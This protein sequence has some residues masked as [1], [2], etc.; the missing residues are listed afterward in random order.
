MFNFIFK[1][2][3][4]L[5]CVVV[6][7]SPT[8]KLHFLQHYP[9]SSSSS[10]LKSV[11]STPNLHSF[12]VDYLIK[13]C[14]FPPEK[15]LSASKYTNFE[16]PDKPDSVL[17][18]FRNHGF[19]DTQISVLIRKLPRLLLS[20]P[21]NTLLPKI[22]FFH[23][24]GFSTQ[25]ITKI[26]SAAPGVLRRSLENQ[27]IPAYNFFKALLKTEEKT[28]LVIKRFARILLYDDL[29]IYVI[30]NIE[31]LREIGVPESNIVGLFTMQ[32]RAFI[33]TNT[34]RF[35][36]IVEEVKKMGFNPTKMMFGAAIHALR[37][38]SKSTWEKKVEVFKKWGFSEDDILVAFRKHPR[39]M[40]AS[41]DK[42]I[43][44]MD[45]FVN[46]MGWESS[47]VAR[48]AKLVSLCLER[49]IIP[50]CFFYQILLSKGLIKKGL[51]LIQ[52]LDSTESYFLKK[53]VKKYEEEAPELLKLY[54]DRLNLSK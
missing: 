54:Q 24:K 18:L 41:E 38:M 49:R 27:I 39:F 13:S 45:F 19:T 7:T 29:H 3:P 2:F 47:I 34:D 6:S 9:L 16:T 14:G 11:S 23:S 43:G 51:G 31:A 20:D 28:K 53:Y 21:E 48:R 46:R 10:A 52:M 33:M 22:E 5:R 50:R 30:P 15:A 44:L 25:D 32:P 12:T 26:V 35:K 40:E 17:T 42:I 1:S 8:H 4:Y 36:E 37:A